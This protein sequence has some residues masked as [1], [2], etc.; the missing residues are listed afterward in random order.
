MDGFPLLDNEDIVNRDGVFELL[1]NSGVGKPG[2]Y[3]PIE[4][5][6][7]GQ[8]GFYNRS[9]SGCYFCFFQQKIEWIWLYEQ[10]HEDFLKAMTYEKDGFT[11]MQDE[12]LEDLIK[13]ARMEKIKALH[14]HKTSRNNNSTSKYLVDV[15]QE[16]EDEG[17]LA[18]FM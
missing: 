14:L 16:S 15:L 13:P 5:E 6:V 1:E 7:N 2:Y 8:K 18:C 12:R 10:H 3:K 11:W 9:R 17:C 4:F